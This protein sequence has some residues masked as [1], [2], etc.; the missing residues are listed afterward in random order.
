MYPFIQHIS[1]VLPHVEGRKEFIHVIKD[2][3][4]VVDYVYIDSSSLDD[5][6]RA[7]CRGIKFDMDGNILARPFNKFFNYGERNIAY[8]WDKDYV[9]M[10]KADGSMIHTAVVN[11]KVVFMTRMGRTEH[12]IKAERHLTDLVRDHCSMLMLGG[13][14]PIFEWVSP[15]NQIVIPY[16]QDRLILLAIRATH[17]G[18][19][20]VREQ[21]EQWAISMGIPSIDTYDLTLNDNNIGQIRQEFKGIEGFVVF[22]P[23]TQQYVKIKTD[24][25]V[26]M[27]RAVSFFEREDM[28]L[29]AVLDSQCDDLYPTLSPERAEKLRKYEADVL[30]CAFTYRDLI[31]QDMN[32][33]RMAETR[34]DFALRVNAEVQPEL[35]S[36]YFSAL[37]GKDVWTT[38]KSVLCKH[39]HL[40]DVRW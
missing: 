10:G 9:V 12:A 37:D 14:T 39:P 15:E 13:F 35:R 23:E 28:I 32:N 18:S 25:Y 7:E 33:F 1:D 38:L 30:S 8:P 17:S 36:V 34:K 19:Y 27:H 6:I 4:Q 3:Y 21:V 40:L 31:E 16:E 5:P 22:F 29:P 24:E 26:Q 2:G 20:L 11:N